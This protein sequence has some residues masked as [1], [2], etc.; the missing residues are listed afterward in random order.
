[1]QKKQSVAGRRGKKRKRALDV[2]SKM[3][4]NKIR[5]QRNAAVGS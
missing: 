4:W 2:I 5:S 3:C 1:M